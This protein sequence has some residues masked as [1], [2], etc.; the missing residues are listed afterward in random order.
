MDFRAWF[1]GQRKKYFN[2]PTPVFHVLLTTAASL[3][4]V[5]SQRG[6]SRWEVNCD[7]GTNLLHHHVQAVR[8]QDDREITERKKRDRV[9]QAAGPIKCKTAF[10]MK[11][12]LLYSLLLLQDCCSRTR[13][14]LRSARI[15][16]TQ[17]A[18]FSSETLTDNFSFWQWFD[19][20]PYM[21]SRREI[22][23]TECSMW[24]VLA[25]GQTAHS[26]G[27]CILWLTYQVPG[28]SV[29]LLP[30]NIQILV[31]VHRSPY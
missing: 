1:Q 7:A 24:I 14:E 5:F 10:F 28:A 23:N 25:W 3:P 8:E 21:L 9:N 4:A 27:S 13:K 15:W 19:M 26:T 22:Y 17:P 18:Q 12:G 31:V 29:L 30:L 20:K 16:V 2:K 11:W 6:I